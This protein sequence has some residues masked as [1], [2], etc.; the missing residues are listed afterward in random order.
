MRRRGLQEG[1][2]V[3]ESVVCRRVGGRAPLR[4][5]TSCLVDCGG[6]RGLVQSPEATRG[7]EFERRRRAMARTRSDHKKNVVGCRSEA[8]QKS[9]I[10]TLRTHLSP[11]K[12]S[13]MFITSTNV[14]TVLQI[15][16]HPLSRISKPTHR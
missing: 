5:P 15:N 1:R 7:F 11:D 9:P 4:V 6:V 13:N 10:A 14:V 8:I 3:G 12:I 16:Y 2:R